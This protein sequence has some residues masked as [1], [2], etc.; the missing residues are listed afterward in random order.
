MTRNHYGHTTVD[1]TLS[2]VCALPSKPGTTFVP[3]PSH[4]F[5]VC[6]MFQVPGSK[7]KNNRPLMILTL[8][9]LEHLEHLEQLR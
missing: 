8:Q 4:L 1:F 5:Q 9:N 7:I 6:S 3:I 2:Q